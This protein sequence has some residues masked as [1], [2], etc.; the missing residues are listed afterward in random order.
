MRDCQ[1]QAAAKKLNQPLR[2]NLKLLQ[3]LEL[4]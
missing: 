4:N 1:G 2:D 3:Y